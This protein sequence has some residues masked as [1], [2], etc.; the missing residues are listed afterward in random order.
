[1]NKNKIAIIVLAALLLI[2]GGFLY[3]TL[4]EMKNIKNQTTGEMKNVVLENLKTRR[5]IRSFKKMQVTDED[6]NAVLEAGTY[7]PSGMNKQPSLMV[8]VQNPDTITKIAKLNA[9]VFGPVDDSNFKNPFYGAPT[10]VIVFADT[11]SH[12][13]LEDGSLV[14]GNLLNAAHAVGLGSC[15]IHRA[16]EVFQMPEGK[17]LMKQWGIPENYVGIGNCI[18]GYPE[19]EYPVAKPR[20]ADYIRKVD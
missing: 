18:L 3:K 20:K 14:M 5:S 7:A 4:D 16:R 17:A 10:L 11:T 19:G 12:T 9:S 15:W 1:M 8:V 2:T 13:Y 6:L